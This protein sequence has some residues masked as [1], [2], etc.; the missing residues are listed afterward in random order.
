MVPRILL[1]L[2]GGTPF[3]VGMFSIQTP[4]PFLVGQETE[5]QSSEIASWPSLEMLMEKGPWLHLLAQP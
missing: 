4:A 2:D 1:G 5:A 3:L